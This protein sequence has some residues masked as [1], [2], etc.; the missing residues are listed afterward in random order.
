MGGT[1]PLFRFRTALKEER[2][3]IYRVCGKGSGVTRKTHEGMFSPAG[4]NTVRRRS[5]F[6]PTLFNPHADSIPQP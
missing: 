2:D 3:P 1:L 6:T 4:G 5:C